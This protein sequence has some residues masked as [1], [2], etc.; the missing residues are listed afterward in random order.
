MYKERYKD[1][2]K[3]HPWTSGPSWRPQCVHFLLPPPRNSPGMSLYD[4]GRWRDGSSNFFDQTSFWVFTCLSFK[5]PGSLYVVNTL[6][7]HYLCIIVIWSKMM[8]LRVGM[9]SMHSS[10][11]WLTYNRGIL[12]QSPPVILGHTQRLSWLSTCGFVLNYL[13]WS[14]NWFV[15][16]RKDLWIIFL[17]RYKNTFPVAIMCDWTL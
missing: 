9:K 5:K 14:S 3:T 2:R 10:M 13:L 1:D 8:L 12:V 11:K 7:Y 15:T 4:C 17:S 6:K 16:S